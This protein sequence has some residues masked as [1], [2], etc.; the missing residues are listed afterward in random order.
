MET[1]ADPW[2]SI[3]G[4]GE[5]G[6]DGLSPA[7]RAA[8]NGAEIVFGGP[9]HLALAGAGARGREWPVPFSTAP[10]LALRGR[11]V[12]VLA[13]GDPFWFGAGG[14]LARDLAPEEWRAFPAP[15]TFSLIAARLGWRIEDTACLGLHAAP[16]QRL[17]PLLARGGR[18]IVLL[19]DAQAVGDLARWLDGRATITVCEAVG[20]PDERIR[21]L[22]QAQSIRAPVA[23]ALEVMA[24]PLP[25]PPGIPD[26]HFAHD[27]QITKAPVRAMTLA[28]LAPYAGA[29]LWDIGA[30]SGSVSVEW[31]LLGGA[32]QALERRADRL[33]NITANARRFGVED[34]LTPHLGTA[35]DALHTLP[36]PDVVFIGGGG[37]RMVFEALFAQPT[38]PRIVANAVTLETQALLIA[39][40]GE[41]GGRLMKLDLA[42][43]APLGTMNGWNAAR[44]LVQWVSA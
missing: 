41:R 3:I 33:A 32:S 22:D 1:S 9:R 16:F 4:I 18:A 11:R 20:G 27:G 15:S 10:V 17:S 23:V 29:M 34:R 37:S 8:L 30:G 19:R 42:E 5:D 2:L 28:A 6:P 39:L 12:A 7:S 21:P 14:S 36:P 31:C 44:T 25:L 13:S 38:R 26:D 24:R 35:P 40:H 43:A